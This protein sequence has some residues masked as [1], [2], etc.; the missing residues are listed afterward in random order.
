MADETVETDETVEPQAAP[1]PATGTGTSTG[2]TTLAVASVTGTIV[3]GSV[4]TGAGVPAGTTLVRQTSGPPGGAGNYITSVATTLAGIPITFTPGPTIPFFP[5]FVTPTP[6]VAGGYPPPP[7]FPP[8]SPN[9]T[10]VA[11]PVGPKATPEPVV[12]A[13]VPP[14]VAGVV[15]PTYKTGSATAPPANGYFPQFT[16]TTAYAG[17]PNQPPAGVP[18]VFTN[19]F[20]GAV[21]A[22]GQDPP[23]TWP[24]PPSTPTTAQITLDG[25]VAQ[26]PPWQLAAMNG[27]EQ[28]RAGAVHSGHARPAERRRRAVLSER[29]SRPQH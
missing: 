16:T 13:A 8:L 18:I 27:E 1:P 14:S 19:T 22:A 25:F 15:Q 11:V 10:P 6:P 9:T 2:T 7:Q 5:D 20:N 26:H 23:W 24:M 17:F 28:E 21:A 4:M 29:D 12:P 3:L